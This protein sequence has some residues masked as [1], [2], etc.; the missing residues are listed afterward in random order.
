MRT[1]QTNTRDGRHRRTERGTKP[2]PVPQVIGVGVG[3]DGAPA[4]RDAVVLAAMLARSTQAELGWTSVKA[5][6][7][8][9]ST[10]HTL[11]GDAAAPILTTPRPR[12]AAA[13]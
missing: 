2:A 8:V 10:G 5:Q 9:G 12:H 1:Q 6:A 3:V 11:A 7:H 4:G 13:V